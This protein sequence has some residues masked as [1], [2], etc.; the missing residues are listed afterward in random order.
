ME[1]DRQAETAPSIPKPNSAPAVPIPFRHFQL[2]TGQNVPCVGLGT[3]WTKVMDRER[4]AIMISTAIELG[5]RHF[6]TAQINHNE[7]EIG[8]ALAEIYAKGKITREMIFHSSKAWNTHHRPAN[9]R[10]AL[11][12]TLKDLRYDYLDLYS[13]HWPI[14]F[15]GPPDVVGVDVPRGPMGEVWLDVEV[16][17]EDT[18]RE[19]EKFVAEG[20]VRALGIC[21][22]PLNK[23][24]WLLDIAKIK[25]AVHQYETHPYLPQPDLLSFCRKNEITVMAYAPLGIT[26]LLQDPTIRS[27]AEKYGVSSAK[28]LVSRAVQRGTCA[29]LRS[30]DAKHMAE[31][32]E[33]IKLDTED[34]EL[35]GTMKTRIRYIN[36]IE[37]FGVDLFAESDMSSSDIVSPTKPL[38]ANDIHLSV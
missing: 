17:L 31:N 36:P 32:L 13:L 12:Q 3:A 38:A 27:I 1:R 28:V 21:N 14:S 26:N 37:L 16:N 2:Y 7:K 4:I 20:K 9:L 11:E 6:D 35:M 18:W 25:P 22:F 34:L 19:M 15:L 33:L 29:V 30:S 24:K 10:A 23:V 5:Y 8:D